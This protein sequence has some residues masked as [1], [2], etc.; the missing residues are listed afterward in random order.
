[1][2]FQV[3]GGDG[4][5]VEAPDAERQRTPAQ[6]RNLRYECWRR[7]HDDGLPDAS[8]R[9]VKL[10]ISTIARLYGK[11]WHTVRDGIEAARH[12]QEAIAD[13]RLR[14]AEAAAR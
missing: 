9:L 8:G 10:D 6:F 1:M 4:R 14:H 13:V 2:L 11:K 3:E 12:I 5:R 7:A